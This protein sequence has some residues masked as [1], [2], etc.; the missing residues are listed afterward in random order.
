[1]KWRKWN[2][3]IHRDLGYLCVGLT[4]IYSISGIAVNHVD[5]WNPNY[6]IIRSETEIAPLIDSTFSNEYAQTYVIGELG[7]TDSVRSIF[8]SGPNSIKIFFQNKTLSADLKTG[9][10]NLEVVESKP[11]LRESNYLHLNVPKKTWTYIADA[12]AVSLIIL[13][14]TGLFII[15]GKNGITGRGLWLTAAGF[16]LPL[17]FL[18]IYYW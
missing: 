13:A 12:F 18:L 10:V 17:L 14:V 4:I 2:R 1:M 15:K 16:L 9:K 6:N 8:R 5:E 7:I 3:I 11:V